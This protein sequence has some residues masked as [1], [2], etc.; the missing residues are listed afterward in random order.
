M[1][2][3]AYIHEYGNGKLEPEHFDV[4]STLES[5]GIVC[6]LFTTK[7]LSRNQ[8]NIDN[9]T[10]VVGDNPTIQ[11]IFKK[12]AYN[13]DNDSYPEC[14][15]PFLKRPVWQSSVGELLKR[16]ESSELYNLFIKPRNKAKL[17]TGFVVNSSQE[18]QW[19][20]GISKHTE[21]Y[22][23]SVVE[24]QSEYRIF[25]NKSAIVGIKNYRGDADVNLDMQEVENAITAFEN[26]PNKTMSYGVD[27]GVL[28]NGDT[29][30]VE[31]NDGFALGSYGLDKEIYTDLIIARWEEV[32]RKSFASKK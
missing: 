8:L 25:V 14:L 27:F 22:C 26:S 4:K 20:N 10:L 19:L 3:K 18:L 11:T 15:G 17:F 28:K 31:W 21:L 1:I 6:E 12:L 9:S 29:A 5:R 2:T 30:L 23:S 13:N 24:W 16:S 7:R 32:L